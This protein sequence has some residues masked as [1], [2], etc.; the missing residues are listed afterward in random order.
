LTAG[1]SQ[2]CLYLH[3]GYNVLVVPGDLRGAFRK[4]LDAF[5]HELGGLGGGDV[6]V[7]HRMR[8]ASR[9]LRECLPL[10]ELEHDATRHLSRRLRKVTKQLG[11]VRE[12][13]VLMMLAVELAE[14]GRYSPRALNRLGEETAKAR[15]SAREHLSSTLP[16]ANLERLARKLDRV[17]RGLDSADVTSGS[18]REA[19]D[20]RRVWLWALE[21]RLARRATEV[22]VAIEAAG[23]MYVPAHLHR[24]RI[25]VKKLRY[26]AELVAETTRK[27]I[28]IDLAGLK[29]AQELLGR[30]HDLDV[31]LV[32][33]RK[34]QASLVPLDLRA[35]R[36]L[37]S[38]VHVVEGDCRQLHA[39]Y[40]RDRTGL[41]AV[42]N[43]LAAG[44][45]EAQPGGIHRTLIAR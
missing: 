18:L 19:R 32:H 41:M 42:A 27:R 36:D 17:A 13:D 5:A 4:R 1:G 16:A 39:R 14:D 31:L 7:L 15:A 34:A 45:R 3:F 33:V 6:E 40:M 11:T 9:R 23:A 44:T 21:A 38:L 28:T 26:A 30:L 2:L 35:W 22:R 8:V 37:G 12:L 20:L 43:R 10:L 25:A 29:G 24:I